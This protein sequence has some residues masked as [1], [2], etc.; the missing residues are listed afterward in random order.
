MEQ[1]KHLM[2]DIRKT[3]VHNP[4]ATDNGQHTTDNEQI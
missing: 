4:L 1:K 3:M 2:I